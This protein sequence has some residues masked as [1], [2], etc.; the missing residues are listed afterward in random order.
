MTQPDSQP[1]P[2]ATAT[3]LAGYWRP[4]SSAEQERA[5]ILLGAAADLINEQPGSADF[6]ATACKWVSLDMVKRVMASPGGA[7]VKDMSESLDNIGSVS[8]SYVNPAGN[9]YLTGRELDRLAGRPAGGGAFSLP[10]TSNVRVPS[11]PWNSQPV[12]YT[13]DSDGSA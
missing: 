8:Y 9:L 5:T 3:D 2:Y 10:L 7:G 6:V 1:Q 13:G 4:L 12:C 11:E